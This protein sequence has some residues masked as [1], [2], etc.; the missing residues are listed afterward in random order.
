MQM[1]NKLYVKIFLW[2]WLT[3]AATMGSL[4][5]LTSVNFSDISYEPLRKEDAHSLKRIA[6]SLERS[7]KRETLSVQQLIDRPRLK[8]RRQLYVYSPEL[9]EG[10]RNFTSVDEN[11]LSLLSFR[12]D[13]PP[14]FIYHQNFQAFGPEL[15]TLPEGQYQLFEI[16]R[17][18]TLPFMFRL[19]FV[20][21]WVKVAV[22]IGA[23]LLLSFIFTRTLIG[24]IKSLRSS[25]NAIAEGNLTARVGP[26]YTRNDELGALAKD[27][28]V[29]AQRLETLVTSQRSLLGDISHE[30]RSPLTRLSLACA[31]AQEQEHDRVGEHLARIDKEAQILDAMIA[32]ILMLSRLENRQQKLATEAISVDTLLTPVFE[33]AVF[34][35][36]SQQKTLH[37]PHIDA[38]KVMNID[39]QLIASAIENLLRNAIKYARS[40]IKVSLTVSSQLFELTIHDDGPGV[41]EQELA[42]ITEPFYRVGSARERQGG[43]TGLGLA[44]ADKA[45]AAHKG[46]LLLQNHPQG[47]LVARIQIPTN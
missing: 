34:E 26:S 41:P 6:H 29:M 16:R 22:A 33:N 3:L 27:F 4:A 1:F 42:H 25:T 19:R 31:M 30:L 28:N 32:R 36:Q 9:G 10:Y 5:M 14:Q 12:L 35:A 47:G 7:A 39:P 13:M 46:V 20:P 40:H 2:F 15:I 43:G 18:G 17:G 37:I 38:H 11:E 23:S 8:T 21:S 44:I 24:P 45:I